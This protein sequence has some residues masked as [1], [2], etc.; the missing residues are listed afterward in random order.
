VLKR[1]ETQWSPSTDET[2]G[3][4]L[5]FSGTANTTAGAAFM[6]TNIGS[7]TGVRGIWGRATA[8]SGDVTGVDGSTESSSGVGVAGSA[9]S[10]SGGCGSP[11]GNRVEP[12][13]SWE[14]L[15]TVSMA[16]H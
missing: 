1:S 16:M 14:P 2:G 11:A 10:S 8:T 9:Y 3:L 5:P 6:A 12:M 13:V 7:N 4:S 15:V